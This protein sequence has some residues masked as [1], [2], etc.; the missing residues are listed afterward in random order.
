[1]LGVVY[2]QLKTKFKKKSQTLT[3][4]ENIFKYIQKLQLEES[5]KLRGDG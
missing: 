2:S 3:K 4:E 5:V 1:M